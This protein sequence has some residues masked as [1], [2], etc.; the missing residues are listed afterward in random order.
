MAEVS[1]SQLMSIIG[2]LHVQNAL[3]RAEVDRLK[4]ALI[5]TATESKKASELGEAKQ[6]A[7]DLEDGKARQ[8]EH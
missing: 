6:H 5:Q 2:E 4:Q 7:D 3:L 8:E 1:I